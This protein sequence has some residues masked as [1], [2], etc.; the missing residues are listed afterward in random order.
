MGVLIFS[1]K[2]R[3]NAIQITLSNLIMSRL[4]LPEGVLKYL[5]FVN[6]LADSRLAEIMAESR[7]VLDQFYESNAILRRN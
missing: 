2:V 1:S 6:S 7:L 5:L 3:S 4:L